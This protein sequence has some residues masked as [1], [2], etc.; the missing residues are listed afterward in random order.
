LSV[1]MEFDTPNRWM[2]SV[3]NDTACSAPE[4]RDWARLDP[5]RELIHDDEQV[6][7]APGRLSQGPDDVHPRHG[8]RPCDGNRLKGMSREI[9]FAG[10]ELAPLAGSY[11][12]VG[13]SDCGGL[14]KALAKCVAH[15]G[16]RR[17]VV[18]THTHMDVSNELATL[19]D[20]DAPL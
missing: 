5:L 9:S 18:A 14:V 12:L 19:G 1:M 3:K 13:V 20:G 2:M 7:V 11:D 16:T 4:V 6:S 17:R 15:E 10:I 8:K